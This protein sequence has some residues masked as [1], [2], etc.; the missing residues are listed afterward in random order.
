MKGTPAFRSLRRVQSKV[1]PRPPGRVASF[2]R[3][4]VEDQTIHDLRVLANLGKVLSLRDR[5]CLHNRQSKTR[6][7]GDDTLRRF[8]AVKL[9]HVRF[10]GRND[11]KQRVI[12]GVDGERDFSGAPVNALAERARCLKPEI[13]RAG[14]EEH[15]TNQIGTGINRYIKRLRGPEAADFDQQWHCEA[16]SSAFSNWPQSGTARLS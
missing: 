7:Y 15:E 16:R 2:G 5:Q 1:L 6:A 3:A 4:R 10:E 8:T 14:R 12:I 13:A 11:V 9:K